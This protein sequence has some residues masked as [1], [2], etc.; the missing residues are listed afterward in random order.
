MSI[1]FTESSFVLTGS[2]PKLG[3]TWR[4]RRLQG[5]TETRPCIQRKNFDRLSVHFH[6]LFT[7]AQTKTCALPGSV[8]FFRHIKALENMRPILCSNR[9]T[10]I[11]NLNSD[12]TIL[13]QLSANCQVA[14][15]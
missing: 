13:H 5:E 7:D 14:I 2:G 10:V 15:L 4:L 12:N 11:F 3:L 1:H 8:G 6:N 9:F